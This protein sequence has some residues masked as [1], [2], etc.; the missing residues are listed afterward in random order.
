MVVALHRSSQHLI[1]ASLPEDAPAARGIEVTASIADARRF[2]DETAID[3]FV[4]AHG[5]ATADWRAMTL[6]ALA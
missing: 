3:D 2:A 6:P 4:T 1:T 5:G